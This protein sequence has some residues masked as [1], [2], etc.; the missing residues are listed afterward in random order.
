M[1]RYLAELLI[2]CTLL[3]MNQP[4][5]AQAP[6]TLWTKTIGTD[7][8]D[9]GNAVRQTA[10]GGFIV[11]GWTQRPGAGQT[12]MILIRTNAG[13][14][15]LWTKAF[16]DSSLEIGYS[17]DL[18]SDGGYIMIGK[19]SPAVLSSADLLLVRTDA[20]GAP[21]WTRTY[22]TE[23]GND[24]GRSVLQ[25][26]DSGFVLVG[27]TT[28]FGAGQSDVWL[29]RTNANGDTLWSKTYG[30]SNIEE[31][32]SIDRTSDGG[33]IIS[34]YTLSFGA[35]NVDGWLI[36]TDAYGDTLWTRTYGG[37]RPD[38]PRAVQ[39]TSGGGFIMTGETLA[40]G[41]TGFDVWLVRT[42]ANGDTLWTKRY[43]EGSDD[44]GSSVRQTSDG[45]FIIAGEYRVP[46]FGAIPDVWLIRTDADGDTL[47]TKILGGSGFDQAFSVQQTSD[48]GYIAVGRTTSFGAGGSDPL[49]I[50]VSPENP[51]GIDVQA[52]TVPGQFQLLQNYPNPF[53]PKTIIHYQL[54]TDS[55]VSLSVYDLLGR[56]VAVLV[57]EKKAPGSYDVDFDA[58]G[59][60]S[61]VYLYRLTAGQSFQTRQMVLLR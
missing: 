3:G 60:A 32:T 27:S 31:A 35:G 11:A 59:L 13:G 61:G 17:L 2:V 41:Q 7:G 19:T 54:S 25:T 58:S 4:A 18:T 23:S 21:M 34:A 55:Y 22:G 12:D 46:P 33:F 37:T 42:D 39:Q 49:L 26:S 20:N 44:K 10:D 8:S 51:T 29:I 53:N 48:G 52:S 45:G 36:R 14:D 40:D 6:D 47:W 15:T 38:F 28:S 24:I 16:G 50:R 43:G 5:L 56:E 57:N 30:G 9:D 1:T